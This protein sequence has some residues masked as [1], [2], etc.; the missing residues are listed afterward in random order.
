[1]RLRP[2]LAQF[3]LDTAAGIPTRAELEH[4]AVALACEW[5]GVAMKGMAERMAA[6]VEDERKWS[7]EDV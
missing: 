6:R 3:L 5:W 7:E 4:R 2:E 1:M